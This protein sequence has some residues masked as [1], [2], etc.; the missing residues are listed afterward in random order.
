MEKNQTQ[1]PAVTLFHCL[2]CTF[3]NLAAIFALIWSVCISAVSMLR[4]ISSF[5]F[6]SLYL[7]LYFFST[8]GF[9]NL[10][11]LLCFLIKTMSSNEQFLDSWLYRFFLI[12]LLCSWN[13][14]T[15]RSFNIS[16]WKNKMISS[17]LKWLGLYLS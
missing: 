14:Y 10:L 5:L 3:S 17:V 8:L 6:S 12:K 15:L 2:C 7:Q 13:I 16:A 9:R 4:L 1:L 11:K